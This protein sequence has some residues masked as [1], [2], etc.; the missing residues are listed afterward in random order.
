MSAAPGAGA[1]RRPWPP[2]TWAPTSTTAAAPDDAARRPLIH[3]KRRALQIDQLVWKEARK[4]VI[5]GYRTLTTW[6][7]HGG[8]QR[9]RQLRPRP[10]PS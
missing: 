10:M 4:E 2:L 8:V 7:P 6:V 1:T 3:G 9:E 5:A